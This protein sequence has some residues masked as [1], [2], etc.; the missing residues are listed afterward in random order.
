MRLAYRSWTQALR[1][2]QRA[3]AR[4]SRWA[5]IAQSTASPRQSIATSMSVIIF[6]SR[7]IGDA[8]KQP[9][10]D[11]V[12][13]IKVKKLHH[14]GA[15][16]VQCANAH[17]QVGVALQGEHEEAWQ[18]RCEGAKIG[19][20]T[21]DV[22]PVARETKFV[23]RHDETFARDLKGL[24]HMAL[25]KIE[26]IETDQHGRMIRREVAS[27]EE[28]RLCN[29]VKV[30]SL[31]GFAQTPLGGGRQAGPEH[32]RGNGVDLESG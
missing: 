12:G 32:G 6:D 18:N 11:L 17:L 27:R 7:T 13:R 25:V 24:Q 10:I 15:S 4:R 16:F 22:A 1:G 14:R 23:R 2:W 8:Q 29:V 28:V 19:V 26:A 21:V 5:Q 3:S 20:L 31:A 9:G 30:V